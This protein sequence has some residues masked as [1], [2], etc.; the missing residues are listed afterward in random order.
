MPIVR[1]CQECGQVLPAGIVRHASCFQEA[2]AR[3]YGLSERMWFE[4]YLKEKRMRGGED[5]AQN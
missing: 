3:C 1:A 2:A 5:R 4:R